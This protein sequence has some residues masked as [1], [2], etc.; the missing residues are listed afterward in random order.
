[1]GSLCHLDLD[2]CIHL[3]ENQRIQHLERLNVLQKTMEQYPQVPPL[4]SDR[5]GDFIVLEG[6][7]MSS[8]KRSTLD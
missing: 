8:G 3:L 5:F 6:G 4:E 1:M 2:T 7:D